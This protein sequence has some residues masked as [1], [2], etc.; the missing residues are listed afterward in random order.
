VS[1]ARPVNE[2]VE[3]ELMRVPLVSDI[4]GD[5]QEHH[6][7]GVVAALGR[8]DAV[9]LGPGLGQGVGVQRFFKPLLGELVT[10]KIPTVLDADALN[11]L[12]E[13][14][15]SLKMLGGRAVIVTPHPGEA[16]R[17]LERDSAMIQ[18]DR[19]G[20]ARE[21][22]NELGCVVVLK[23]AGTIV[24]GD[25]HGFVCPF[26]TPYLAIPGSGDVLSGFIG[27]LIAQG[28]S[29]IEAGCRGVVIHALAGE[30]AHR[31]RGGFLLASDVITA[32]G[33]T[34]RFR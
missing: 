11:L 6:L 25:S 20:A 27:A 14:R 9:V 13:D 31:A 29:S 24:Y 32:V 23:G 3:P 21:L 26:G 15:E 18:C 34:V 19:F 4:A 16:G 17:L 8:A 30:N 1:L 33:K 12:S 22:S 2:S 7:A 10:R 5:F 28:A